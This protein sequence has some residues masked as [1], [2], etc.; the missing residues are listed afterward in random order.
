MAVGSMLMEKK[1]ERKKAWE[2]SFHPC[3]LLQRELSFLIPV[4][5]SVNNHASQVWWIVLHFFIW[6]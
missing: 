1:K 4:I 3:L 6:F 5:I 2:A